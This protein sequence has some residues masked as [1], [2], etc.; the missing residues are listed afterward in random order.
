[1]APSPPRTLGSSPQGRAQNFTSPARR[2]S[3][4]PNTCTGRT[5]HP[6]ADYCLRHQQFGFGSKVPAAQRRSRSAN[7]YIPCT[8]SKN[9]RTESSLVS[10]IARS[11]VAF[12]SWVRP[13][14]RSMWPRTA[15]YG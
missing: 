6:L 9:F 12:A 4:R 8:S 11:K 1:M 7:F 10:P 2:R 3:R 13:R 15:Q 14:S 5:P